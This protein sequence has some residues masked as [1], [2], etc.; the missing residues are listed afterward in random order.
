[1][2]NNNTKIL[3]SS[4]IQSV[5]I[6]KLRNVHPIV[7]LLFLSF[8][9][10]METGF[11]VGDL[12][13]NPYRVFLLFAFPFSFYFYLK[14]IEKNLIDVFFIAFHF[15]ILLS[16]LLHYGFM[17]GVESSGVLIL[18]SL[19]GYL[20]GRCFVRNVYQFTGFVF[21][22]A[23]IISILVIFV[24][25][26]ALSGRHYIHE[27][28]GGTHAV[29]KRMGFFRSMGPFDHPIHFGAFCASFLGLFWFL[30][31][32]R[33]VGRKLRNVGLLALATFTSLSSAPFLMFFIQ[34]GAIAWERIASPLRSRWILAFILLTLVFITLEFLSNRGVIKI[35][36]DSFTLNPWTGY[37]RIFIWNYG[38]DEVLRHPFFGI[39]YGDWVRPSWMASDSVDNFWLLEAMRFGLPALFF[40]CAGI[41]LLIKRISQLSISDPIL[42]DCRRGWLISISA[43]CIAGATVHFWGALYI[44]FFFLLGSIAWMLEGNSE[45]S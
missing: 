32:Y 20:I 29:E 23:V 34:A 2:L 36:I 25:P 45:N 10:P 19:G 27:F 28:F 30:S 11:F 13:L 15:W 43:L 16:F 44:H 3:T 41:L 18:E 37:Y 40:L 17:Q 5:S 26:E 7:G 33:G 8:M 14:R 12:Y 9:L 39:G 4:R 1:M 31:N 38:I 6:G 42:K 22:V 35:L 24:L 21:L